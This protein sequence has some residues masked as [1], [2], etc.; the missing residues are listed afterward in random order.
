MYESR[1]WAA[2]H[3]EG[4]F[5]RTPPHDRGIRGIPGTSRNSNG[6]HMPPHIRAPIF[7]LRVQA[8]RRAWT[9]L[10][11][12]LL[13]E[14]SASREA[15]RAWSAHPSDS[16]CAGWVGN[17]AARLCRTQRRLAGG[18]RS[19]EAPAPPAKAASDPREPRASNDATESPDDGTLAP[20]AV[21]AGASPKSAGDVRSSGGPS[22]AGSSG[23]T[24]N[25]GGGA[26]APGKPATTPEIP[27]QDRSTNPKHR[28]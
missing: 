14:P 12:P 19:I 10:A 18:S 2:H 13:T 20:I 23:A 1:A 6:D 3:S 5:V 15:P 7:T 21:D 8:P 25:G 28:R 9:L 26:G 4:A 27:E 16:A 24:G 17:P 11:E 22:A